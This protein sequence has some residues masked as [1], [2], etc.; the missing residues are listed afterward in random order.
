MQGTGR[1]RRLG[2]W[3]GRRPKDTPTGLMEMSLKLE[4]GN[5]ETLRKTK[6][7]RNGTHHRGVLWWVGQHQ[8]RENREE[9]MIRFLSG[10]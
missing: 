4:S 10:L 5:T 9:T 8:I 6:A 7:K 3:V 1:E 2:G